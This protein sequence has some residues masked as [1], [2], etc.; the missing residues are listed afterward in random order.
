MAA[1]GY[2]LS[3]EELQPD[4]LMRQA[5]LAEQAGFDRLAI[6][7]HYHPWTAAQGSSPFVWSMIGALSQ[8]LPLPITTLVTCPTVRIHPAV[9]AQAAATSAVLTDGRFRLGVGTG[10]ALNE[11][12]VGE[13]WP[14]FTER[15]EMLEE[16]VTVMRRLFTGGLVSHDGPHYTVEN[17]RLYTVAAQPPPIYVSAF[18]P[19]AA[20]LAGRIGDGLVTMQPDR[21]LIGLFRDAGGTGKPVV[22]GLKVC[23]DRDR[24]SAVRT[25]RELWAIEA[26]PGE[27]N[28][29]L[30]TTK[31]FEQAM[32][33]VTDEMVQG[34]IVCGS[35][36]DDYVEAVRKYVDAGFTEVYLSHIGPH[37]EEFFA[38]YR[39]EVAPRLESLPDHGRPDAARLQAS[40]V[41]S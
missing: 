2:F 35:D 39:D 7:D 1:F 6:S 10:E 24:E 18:G 9:I 12:V 23:F 11:H 16:A 28:Q 37:Y 26:L 13:R 15:A 41:G 31:H 22:G 27:L 29:V 20:A 25:A 3:C 17:A 38:F 14:A 21:D 19:K 32:A 36:A 34:K 40:S 4:L 5:H 30:P 8:R 33:A